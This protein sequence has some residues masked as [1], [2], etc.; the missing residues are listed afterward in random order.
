MESCQSTILKGYVVIMSDQFEEHIADH[1]D[2]I[3]GIA[4]FVGGWHGFDR[5]SCGSRTLGR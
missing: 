2:K 3:F 4:G 1:D 5:R